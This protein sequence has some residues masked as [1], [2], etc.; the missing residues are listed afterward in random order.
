MSSKASKE[1]SH[2]IIV[3]LVARYPNAFSLNEP[4]VR[5]LKNNIIGDIINDL[6]LRGDDIKAV[7]QALIFYQNRRAYLRS[8]AL[9]KRKRDLKGNR[10]EST[11]WNERESAREKLKLRGAWSEACEHRYQGYLIDKR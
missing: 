6:H 4:E 11:E 8:V 2:K 3:A 7:R 1:K 5:P 10:V 9:G